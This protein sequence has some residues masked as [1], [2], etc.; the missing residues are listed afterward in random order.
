MGSIKASRKEAACKDT[1]DT[2]ISAL[3]STFW[4]TALPKLIM[5][6]EIAGRTTHF[7]DRPVHLANLL[8]GVSGLPEE[9]IESIQL[10]EAHG[11]DY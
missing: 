10:V 3:R 5:G 9:V 6:D 1:G 2:S 7:N 11:A 4:A 8:L